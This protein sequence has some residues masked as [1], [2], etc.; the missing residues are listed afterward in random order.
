[1]LAIVVVA[2]VLCVAV[3][4]VAVVALVVFDDLDEVSLE[5][6]KVDHHCAV[7]VFS[8]C[9]KDHPNSNQNDLL[10]HR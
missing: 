4:G 3:W 5:A 8:P 9:E 6:T 1:M 2:A 10:E 7:S